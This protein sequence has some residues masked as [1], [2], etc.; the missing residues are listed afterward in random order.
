MPNKEHPFLKGRR[1]YLA[2]FLLGV[3]SAAG[4]APLGMWPITLVGLAGWLALH[5]AAD[6][7]RHAAWTGW[8]Y[9]TGYFIAGL[10]WL[11]EPFMV[12]A[13]R[14]GWMAP[15]ALVLMAGGLALFWAAA[16]AG[17]I[18]LRAGRWGWVAL[19]TV[20]ELARAYVFGG[21]PWA[22]PVQVLIDTPAAQALA[23]V[24]PYLLLAGALGVAALVER[25]ARLWRLTALGPALGLFAVLC[26]PAALPERPVE[27][28]QPVVRVVQPN[29]PQREKWDPERVRVFFERS[30][31]LSAGA[32]RPDLVIWPE[33]S[34][35]TWLSRS[36][37]AFA[38]MAG[39]AEVPVIAGINA[40]QGGRAYNALVVV[41]PDGSLAARYDKHHLV[42]FGEYLPAPWLLSRIGLSA[43]TAQAGY[44][45]SA[46]TGPQLV[47]LG[48]AGKAL[49]LICYEAIFPQDLRGTDRPDWLVQITNDA[50]FG[51]FAGPQQHLAQARMRA[52][53]QGLPL[54]RAANTGI[55]AVIDARGRVLEALPLGVAGRLDLRLPA[56][57]APT[58]YARSGDWPTVLFLFVYLLVIISRRSRESV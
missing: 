47:D 20:A 33:T 32:P 40:D 29:A 44:G 31:E 28:P 57:E 15:F 27:G 54:V 49:P 10:H 11:V 19:V 26:L 22:S 46:G 58:L 55:S 2:A 13:A 25:A 45:F 48:V 53:E 4:L 3:V 30:L 35:P 39:A 21:F 36:Q 7:A 14:D 6:G 41:A 43:F 50:W 24:G 17:A 34:V 8:A 1:W 52:I 23:Y 51:T 16:A 12:D 9:A 42:P 38:Q 56:A 37:G 5:L 18:W